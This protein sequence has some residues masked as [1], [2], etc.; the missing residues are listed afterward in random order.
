MSDPAP[1]IPARNCPASHS[2]VAAGARCGT[3]ALGCNSLCRCRHFATPLLALLL[4]FS[5]CAAPPPA[6]PYSPPSETLE[7][8]MLTMINHE[9]AAHAL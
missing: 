1:T 2:A 8:Q 5:G 7:S 4:L 9:R 6:R 3:A